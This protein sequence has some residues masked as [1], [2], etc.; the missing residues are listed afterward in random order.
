MWDQQFEEILRQFLPFLSAGEELEETTNLRDL[1]LDS[2]GIVEM[3]ATL[4]NAYG[5]RFLDDVLTVE[6]F[7][8]PGVLW[9]TLSAMGS[10]AA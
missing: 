4:E 6:T 5:I 8:S 2:M 1:G 7:A 10:Q 3:L 9:T